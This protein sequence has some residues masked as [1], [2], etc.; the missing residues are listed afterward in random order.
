MA[1]DNVYLPPKGTNWNDPCS[2]GDENDI[3]EYSDEFKK[4]DILNESE[5]Q[6]ALYPPVDSVGAYHHKDG[7]FRHPE[8]LYLTPGNPR[9][10]SDSQAR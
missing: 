3:S 7:K 6:D 1:S 5:I 4:L 9:N 8:T 2:L 10:R